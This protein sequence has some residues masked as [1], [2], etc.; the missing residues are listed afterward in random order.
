[1][2]KAEKACQDPDYSRTFGF[3][4]E[5]I[6]EWR[7]PVGILRLVLTMTKDIGVNYAIQLAEWILEGQEEA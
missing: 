1:M 4:N 7:K 3:G 5:T 6:A 2:T